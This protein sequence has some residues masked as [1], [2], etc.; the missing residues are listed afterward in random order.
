MMKKRKLQ[1]FKDEIF[2]LI[3]NIISYAQ[4]FISEPKAFLHQAKHGKFMSECAN[5]RQHHSN[6]F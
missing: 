4:D 1:E 5:R 2:S 3:T 6:G